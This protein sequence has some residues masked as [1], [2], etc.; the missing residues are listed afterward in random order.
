[1]KNPLVPAV[2]ASLVLASFILPAWSA[3]PITDAARVKQ[4]ASELPALQQAVAQAA[5]WKSVP[6]RSA[7]HLLTVT[8]SDSA[9]AHAA[10]R[11]AQAGRMV[12]AIETGIEKKPAF[13]Q[14]SA[15]HVNYEK[16][17]GQGASP[18]QGFDYFKTPAGAFAPHRA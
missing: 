6:V 3:D 9:L 16:G 12:A 18:V 8:V 2:L 1:M 4:Q 13:A 7:A 17:A 5:G 11:E 14:I 10:E 15:I